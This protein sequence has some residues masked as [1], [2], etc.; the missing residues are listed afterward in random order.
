M[1]SELIALSLDNGAI[2]LMNYQSKEPVAYLDSHGNV[3]N[4]L[5]YATLC[6]SPQI[7]LY[8]ADLTAN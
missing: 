7:I 8:P 5:R 4:I 2:S 1:K 6:S 3:S